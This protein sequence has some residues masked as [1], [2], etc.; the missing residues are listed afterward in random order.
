QTVQGSDRLRARPVRGGPVSPQLADLRRYQRGTPGLRRRPIRAVPRRLWPTVAGLLASRIEE[1]SAL[2]LHSTATVRRAVRRQ[3][4]ALPGTRFP[5]DQR[6]P[7]GQR[8]AHQRVAAYLLL[9]R[10]AIR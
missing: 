8:R 5:L 2:Q 7:Q 9:R 10:I 4:N 6:V 3:G 1:Q